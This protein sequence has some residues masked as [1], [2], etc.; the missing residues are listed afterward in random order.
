VD[1]V[2]DPQASAAQNDQAL[3]AVAAARP[4]IT[5]LAMY[6]P[7]AGMIAARMSATPHAYGR[8]FVDLA[9]QGPSFVSAAGAAAAGCLNSGVPSA[10]QLPA[11]KRYTAAYRDVPASG[12][13]AKPPVVILDIDAAGQYTVD[14]AWATVAGYL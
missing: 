4:D 9:A 10:D 12:N 1:A 7:Q 5:Y 6:G 2:L 3:K 14:L 8:C 13:R 11:G